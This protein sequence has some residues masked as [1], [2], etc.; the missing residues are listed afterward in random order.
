MGNLDQ[1]GLIKPFAEA[2]GN[3][4]NDVRHQIEDEP[5]VDNRYVAF[6]VRESCERHQ[7]GGAA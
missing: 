5:W 2:P 1:C 7:N 3:G 6:D 4:E